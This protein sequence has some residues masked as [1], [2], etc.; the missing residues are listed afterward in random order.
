MIGKKHLFFALL[1][2]LPFLYLFSA[3]GWAQGGGSGGG[4]SG[5]G[6]SRGQ[7]S[8][9]RQRPMYLSGQVL[10]DDGQEPGQQIK[11]ELVCQGT[12]I[13]QEFT[14]HSGI[15][16]IEISRGGSTANTLKP[17]D[18]SASTTSYSPVD[19][20]ISSGSRGSGALSSS[21]IQRRQVD[22]SS[23]DLSA[24]LQGYQSDVLRLGRRRALDNPD[25]GVIVL[26]N[27]EG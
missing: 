4:S 10:L 15:F 26:H 20:R 12:V 9:E 1:L 17:M 23:C 5:S 25:I 13:R 7:P 8:G 2:L 11:I 14:S 16:S 19:G 27:L 3:W 21:T 24:R 18:A 22:L 6:G